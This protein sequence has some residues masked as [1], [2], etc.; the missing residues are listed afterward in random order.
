[1]EVVDPQLE[2]ESLVLE[3]GEYKLDTRGDHFRISGQIMS[4]D[5]IPKP[6][7]KKYIH[8]LKGKEFRLDHLS[9][10]LDPYS[11]V[12]EVYRVWWDDKVD[13]PFAEVDVWGESP[14]E[15]E[16][17]EDLI[18]DQ[19]LPPEERKYKGFSIG[20]LT[21]KN[22]KTK[23]IVRIYPRELSIT[24]DP[25]C[26]KCIVDTVQYNMAEHMN[27]Q[28]LSESFKK[29]LESQQG[30]YQKLIEQKDVDIVRI[31]A[32]LSKK[33]SELTAAEQVFTKK[34]ADKTAK[35]T[36]LETECEG[37]KK[38]IEA[39][40]KKI[41]EMEEVNRQ[42]AISPKIDLLLEA[43]GYNRETD[44]YKT[45]KAKW[46]KKTE[47]DINDALEL[48][49]RSG[50]VNGRGLV[51]FSSTALPDMPVN[52]ERVIDASKGVVIKPSVKTMKLVL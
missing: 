27:L 25:A 43:S 51:R 29:Q 36:E 22:K 11:L 46:L 20:V 26:E 38:T 1:M 31:N 8:I 9:P 19:T 40:K 3:M 41:T 33:N 52:L 45:V 10:E 30:L 28:I 18:K 37:Y 4:S 49:K 21:Y 35:I 17:R 50:E 16:L 12:G 44:A 13:E 15:K 2:C 48:K 24:T 7:L 32:E 34:L 39:D 42:L 5:L 14:V 23:V 6:V 47:E